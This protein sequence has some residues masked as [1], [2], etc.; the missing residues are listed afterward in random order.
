VP[1]TVSKAGVVRLRVGCPSS[2]DAGCR[3]RLTLEVLGKQGWTIA[4]TK[5]FD[6]AAGKRV[7]VALKL[8]P[9]AAAL[10]AARKVVRARSVATVGGSRTVSRPFV[11][12]RGR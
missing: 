4:G 9:R 3:G 5:A 1:T 7:Q 8:N 12:R 6:V 2:L 10:L 11:L